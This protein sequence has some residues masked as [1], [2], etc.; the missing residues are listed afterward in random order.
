M[1][2]EKLQK[3]Y[4][5]FI[6]SQSV[7]ELN[8]ALSE[9]NIF[10]ILNVE[11]RE[12]VH[13]NFLAWLM[14]PNETHGLGNV[15]IKSFLR[16]I[17]FDN[18]ANGLTVVDAEN[19]DYKGLVVLR[20]W[21]NIDIFLRFSDLVICIENKIHHSE[22]PNQLKKYHDIVKKE[23][24]SENIKKVFIFL[25]PYGTPSAILPDTYISC[26]Y[27][28]ISD[29]INRLLITHQ[30]FINGSTKLFLQNYYNSIQSY[31]M[32]SSQSIN[33]ARDIYRNHRDLIEFIYANKPVTMK[34]FRRLG[35]EFLLSK[36]QYIGS[37]QNQFI[38]FLPKTI[39]GIVPVGMGSIN[40]GWEKGEAFLLEFRLDAKAITFQIV[41][42]P[43]NTKHE[44]AYRELLEKIIPDNISGSKMPGE[45]WNVFFSDS[46]TSNV[47]EVFLD[48]KKAMRELE[49]L[50]DKFK[51]RIGAV[52]RAFLENKDELIKL[53]EGVNEQH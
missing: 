26:S 46:F 13:S 7:S 52:E 24:P 5:D 14:Q 41:A 20:E 3:E 17:F 10:R 51:H 36:D 40:Y 22:D 9:P 33:I 39:E 28:L 19:I 47:E 32:K 27:Q 30:N 45:K 8:Q 44:S 53:K 4:L 25:N 16:E 2:E 34:E 50:W 18:K 12:L 43:V 37:C 35:I 6:H 1:T 21:R 38:R 23:Y 49:L 15:F 42:P 48:E 11:H 31:L 29:T